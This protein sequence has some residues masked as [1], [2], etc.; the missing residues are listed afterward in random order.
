ME[1]KNE[2]LKHYWSGPVSDLASRPPVP[3][4]S[5]ESERHRIYSLLLMAVVHHY[6]N[7]NKRGR[8]GTYPFNTPAGP[9]AGL[10]HDADYMGHNIAALAVDAE[11]Y[12]VDF[13]FNHN[14]LY[15]SSAEHAEARLIR[16]IYN[17][18]QVNDSWAMDRESNPRTDYTMFEDTTV[19]TSLE[20]C[21]QCTGV[22][23]LGRV[24]QVVYLQPDHGMYMIGNI[25]RNLTE[26]TSLEAPLPIPGDQIGIAQ[27]TMLDR[28]L[29]EF[30]EQL[31]HQ[32][33]FVPGDATGKKDQSVSVTSFLCTRTARDIYGE[34]HTE[35]ERLVRGE[36]P[37]SFPEY[38]PRDRRN[39]L[40]ESALTNKDAVREAE[41][42]FTY[43]TRVAKR[44]T[45][46]H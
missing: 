26:G 37:L 32:P 27:Y 13:E 15:N 41:G 9:S 42:F 43:A 2:K 11:G 12:V 34:A 10:Y 29:D 25:V 46:H 17:L 3:L 7:G 8:N 4:E 6:W 38:R 45:P 24:R 18:A 30:A 35:F 14:A 21:S 40:V 5:G 39:K 23:A 19:Y 1:P 22:M 31:K 28:G 20:S 16:R 44:G 33:F 36:T